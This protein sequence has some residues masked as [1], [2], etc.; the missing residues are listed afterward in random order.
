MKLLMHSQTATMQFE[1]V[2]FQV[3]AVISDSVSLL[4]SGKPHSKWLV[5]FHKTYFTSSFTAPVSPAHQHWRYQS[6]SYI[7][8]VIYYYL[9]LIYS[10]V[11]LST[12]HC[13]RLIFKLLLFLANFDIDFYTK[14]S[15]SSYRWVNA[16][17]T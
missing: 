2:S 16:R 1:Q 10:C 13:Y 17:K 9:C 14:Y 12:I 7:Y 5:K 3:S 6:M 11:L 8:Y 4:W 15:Y